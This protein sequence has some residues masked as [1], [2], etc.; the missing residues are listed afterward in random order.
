MDFIKY[1]NG[2]MVPLDAHLKAGGK[3]PEVKEPTVHDLQLKE[4]TAA[5][6]PEAT[7]KLIAAE[8]IRL[9]RLHPNWKPSKMARK[10]GEKYNV[11]FEFE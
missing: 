11:K 5:D 3:L 8:F 2:L 10:A 9:Q 6:I 1:D 7:K 4:L